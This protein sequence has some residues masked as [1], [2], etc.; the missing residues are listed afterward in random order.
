VREAVGGY[1]RVALA[2]E[3]AGART[4]LSAASIDCEVDGGDL[5]LPD[6]IE[7]LLAWAVREGTTNVVRHSGAHHCAIRLRAGLRDAEV[8][9]LDD[10]SGANGA[11]NGSGLAGLAERAQRLHGEV[12][13]GPRPEGG[14]RLRVSVPTVAAR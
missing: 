13:A 11:A 3:L 10:G 2:D 1:R 9:I 5:S 6:E 4:A 7:S 12:E 8:E 14:F